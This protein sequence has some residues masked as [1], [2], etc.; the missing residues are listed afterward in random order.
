MKKG[1][2]SVLRR[3]QG[4]LTFIKIFDI[5]YIS[6]EERKKKMKDVCDLMFECG[7]EDAY[8][9]DTWVKDRDIELGGYDWD[10][11]ADDRKAELG[12]EDMCQY[13]NVSEF[14]Y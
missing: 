12:Y 7:C 6:N 3:I 14:D 1:N 11:W 9:W 5:I 13:G 8:D 10:V 2:Y 4:K